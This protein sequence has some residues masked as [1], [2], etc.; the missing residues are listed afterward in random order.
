MIQNKIV[1]HYQDG[2]LLKGMTN[3]FFPNKDNFHLT[4]ADASPGTIPLDVRVSEIKAIFFV[5][6]YDGNQS[7]DDKKEFDPAKNLIGR[8]M[9]VTFK[10]GETMVGITNGYEPSRPGFFMTPADPQSNIERC[11]VVTKSTKEVLFI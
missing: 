2:R 10:D 1:I 6:Q 3:N 9:K 4:P 5:R 7:Y 8:K 11:F